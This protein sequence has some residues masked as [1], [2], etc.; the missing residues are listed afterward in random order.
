MPVSDDQKKH[1]DLI[2][3]IIQASTK[4]VNIKNDDGVIFQEQ[5]M[6]ENSFSERF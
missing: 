6:N 4:T 3:L 5:Q 2:D 1:N